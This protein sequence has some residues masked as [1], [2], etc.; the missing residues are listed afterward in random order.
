MNQA[1]LRTLADERIVDAKAL[2]D[3]GRWSFAYYVAGYAIECALK[4]CVLARMIHTGWVYFEK[5][6]LNKIDWRTHEFAKLVDQAGLVQELDAQLAASRAGGQEF[7]IRWG[8][9]TAWRSDVRY[10]AIPQAEA[11]ELYEAITHNPHGVLLW[12]RQYW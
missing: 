10:T 7:A 5:E 12:L 9:V 11:E 2:L 8:K 4:S 3:A 6:K 1:D